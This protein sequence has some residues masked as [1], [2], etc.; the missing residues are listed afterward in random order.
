MVVFR[1]EK[2]ALRERGEDAAELRSL[3]EEKRGLSTELARRVD[4]ARA[5]TEHAEEEAERIRGEAA[6]LR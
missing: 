3:L 4:A 5:R 6:S 1:E 2:E